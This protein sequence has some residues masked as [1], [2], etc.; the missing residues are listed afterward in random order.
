MRGGSAVFFSRIAVAAAFGPDF[1]ELRNVLIL[2]RYHCFF[3]KYKV[4]L[5]RVYLIFIRY[6]DGKVHDQIELAL[7]I[8]RK[9][10]DRRR[11]QILKNKRV[12]IRELRAE[13]VNILP[14]RARDQ[15]P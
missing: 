2:N 8:F 4:D 9:R 10:A 15:Y 6:K 12:D 3:P 13:R 11:S 1:F 5:P 14:C 7:I